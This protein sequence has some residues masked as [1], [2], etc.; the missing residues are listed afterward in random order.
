MN[1]QKANLNI[2][3]SEEAK[4]KAQ[5]M[6]QRYFDGNLNYYFTHLLLCHI[7]EDP[8]NDELLDE[9]ENARKLQRKY[10]RPVRNHEK[11]AQ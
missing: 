2:F 5:I 11:K 6:A 4:A 3:L 9:I 7:Q 1:S 10:E 8:K